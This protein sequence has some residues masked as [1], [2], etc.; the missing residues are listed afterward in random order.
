MK[1]LNK[2]LL[3]LFLSG[4]AACA[5]LTPHVEGL[6]KNQEEKN[7]NQKLDLNVKTEDSKK[8][9]N[10]IKLNSLD[11][12]A[13]EMIKSEKETKKEPKKDNSVKNKNIENNKIEEKT[14]NEKTTVPQTNKKTETMYS[15]IVING[16]K[17]KCTGFFEK[18]KADNIN[19]IQAFIDKNNNV[20]VSFNRIDHTD[21]KVSYVFGHNP[22]PMAPLAKY[23]KIGTEI[24]IYDINGTASQ[25]IITDRKYQ[26]QAGEMNDEVANTLTESKEGVI[27]QFCV[28]NGIAFLIARPKA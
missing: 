4:G 15:T 28:P 3:G 14:K 19:E 21:N 10:T 8:E 12:I 11:S 7:I 27:F 2:G 9:L 23:G 24:T 13:L 17:I 16:Q 26:P 25:Y 5:M 6:D 20:G 1:K 22:G 18:M